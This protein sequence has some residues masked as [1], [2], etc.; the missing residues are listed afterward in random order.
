MVLEALGGA[1]V[2]A[3]D[4]VHRGLAEL[5]VF[6]AQFGT[7]EWDA[8]A[9]S[10]HDIHAG[11]RLFKH[12][13]I[14]PGIGIADDTA[15]PMVVDR[16]FGV[17]TESQLA[18]TRGVIGYG[19]EVEGAFELDFAV[20]REK[21]FLASGEA[22]GIV[23]ISDCLE[24]IGIQRERRVYVKFSEIG[25]PRRAA[26][27]AR[28]A[29]FALGT[30]GLG[31]TRSACCRLGGI[32]WSGIGLSA[33]QACEDDSCGNREEYDSVNRTTTMHLVSPSRA[34]SVPVMEHVGRLIF[35]EW[36]TF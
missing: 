34:E 7:S 16:G 22:I 31:L 1:L 26:V 28:G 29:S 3:P 20:P 8:N 32:V 9:V 4:A 12:L 2:I 17:G 18:H 35:E 30:G 21:D 5:E 14:L 25:V 33:G 36:V 23:C 19:A 6:A 11:L 13:T 24:R 27:D 15:D 10:G